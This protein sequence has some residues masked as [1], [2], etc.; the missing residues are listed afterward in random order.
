[1]RGEEWTTSSLCKGRSAARTPI[2]MGVIFVI[3]CVAIAITGRRGPLD[4]L[5]ERIYDGLARL[6]GARDSCSLPIVILELGADWEEA[7]PVDPVLR[8]RRFTASLDELLQRRPVVVGVMVALGCQVA[9]PLCPKDQL[10]PCAPRSTRD[11]LLRALT[12]ESERVVV[13]ELLERD[14]DTSAV[15][16]LRRPLLGMMAVTAGFT[17]ILEDDGV[18]RDAAVAVAG[19]HGTIKSFELQVAQKA[20]GLPDNRIELQDDHV[21]LDTRRVAARPERR[22]RGLRVPVRQPQVE[23]ASYPL[24]QVPGLD[25]SR[26]IVLVGKQDRPQSHDVTVDRYGRPVAAVVRSA[27]TLHTLLCSHATVRAPFA[28]DLGVVFMAAGLLVLTRR[29]HA[30]WLRWAL[31]GGLVVALLLAA[32]ALSSGGGWELPWVD[33]ALVVPLVWPRASVGLASAAAVPTFVVAARADRQYVTALRKH[34]TQATQAK[35][36]QLWWGPADEEPGKDTREARFE[37]ARL[38][39]ILMSADL[40]AEEETADLVA[41]AAARAREGHAEIIPMRMRPCDLTGNPLETLAAL[42]REGRPVS[43]VDDPD[44]AW[45][46]IAAEVCSRA[47]S[48]KQGERG[49][50]RA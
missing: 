5:H 10:A 17:D 49:P 25:W 4:A 37:E 22:W 43:Q 23:F 11:P 31:G 3:C 41:R 35:V 39:L 34:L 27:L 30:R 2:V 46:D 12:P 28:V 18:F 38:L 47:R 20:L 16:G 1:M 48:L 14:P 45:A 13:A 33:V 19:V 42:P 15:V 21:V 9:A 44:K 24:A 29:A 36:L 32:V 6:A 50:G 8:C 26:R 40:F 7:S